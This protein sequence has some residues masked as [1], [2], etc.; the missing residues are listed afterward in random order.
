MARRAKAQKTRKPKTTDA[1]QVRGE[2]AERGQRFRAATFEVRAEK[3][4]GCDDEVRTVRASVSSEA[5][6][7]EYVFDEEQGRWIRAW[8]ILGHG[9]GEIDTS[10]MADGLVIQDTHEGDQIGIMR[11]PEIRDGKI[12]GEIEFGCGDRAQEI[13]ADAIA[14]IRRNM[15]VG[16]MVNRW[17]NT[18]DVV[19]GLPVY[20]AVSWTPYEASF[21]PVPAD[22]R[23]GVARSEDITHKG[24]IA[25]RKE[26]QVMDK[27]TEENKA[28]LTAENVSEMY[29]LARAADMEAG[30]VD[31]HIK[32]GKSFDEFRTLAISALEKA[33]AERAKKPEMPKAT[34]ER[35]VFDEGEAKAVRKHYSIHRAILSMVDPKVDAGYERE[36]SDEIA[37]QT[38]RAAQG[39]YIPNFIHGQRAITPPNFVVGDSNGSNFVATDLLASEYIEPLVAKMR[40]TEAGMRTITGLRGDIAIP[41]GGLSQGGWIAENGTADATVST[42]GQVTGTPHTASAY[43]D[44]SRKMLLQSSISAEAYTVESL[45]RALRY[46]LET[47]GYSGTG[48]D[49]QPTGIVNTVGVGSVNFVAGAP[50]LSKL[51]D[52]WSAI[53]SAN[54]GSESMAWIATPAVKAILRTTM[55]SFTTTGSSGDITVGLGKY[56]LEQLRGEA[57]CEGYRFLDTTL[58]P[59]KKLLFGDFSQLVLALWSGTDIR[60]DPYTLSN[61]GALR[62]VALQDCDYLVR[63]AAAFAVGNTVLS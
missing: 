35:R 57:F 16:Y 11:S 18:G 7:E 41:K 54:A 62:V 1:P 26:V 52:M 55:D 37:K 19:D 59:A 4:E 47:A 13:K 23:V 22:T 10:R 3:R 36:V 8:E 12:T 61:T 30:I 20:R 31:E 42:L 39:L 15:S 29:R 63:H 33:K 38:G 32:S 58:A 56:L 48:S 46:L 45:D 21:V 50:T 40:L 6:V 5:P 49:A 25:A 2:I 53:E 44:I 9:E 34:D 17:E 27:P 14:G 28:V 24:G 60:V 43:T 51:V